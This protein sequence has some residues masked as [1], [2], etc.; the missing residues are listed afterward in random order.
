MEPLGQLIEQLIMSIMLKESWQW[1]Y[2]GS[3][4]LRGHVK[5]LPA[6]QDDYRRGF[7]SNICTFVSKLATVLYIL[8]IDTHLQA[9]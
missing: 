2:K 8:A 6:L 1:L 9:F 5:G 4:V 3:I 7:F